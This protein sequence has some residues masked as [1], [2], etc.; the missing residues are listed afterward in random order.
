LASADLPVQTYSFSGAP[1]Y[2]TAGSTTPSATSAKAAAIYVSQPTKIS[3]IFY[4]VTTAD[5]TS[6]AYDFGYYGPGCYNAAASIPLAFHTGLTAGTSLASGTGLTQYAITSG[7][8]T[9][10]PGWYCFVISTSATSSIN[11]VLG[12]AGLNLWVPFAASSSITTTGGVLPG[13]IT[14][15]NLSWQRQQWLYLGTTY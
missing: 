5:N 13:T 3:N 9:I 7:P 6:N 4:S 2:T 12:G 15:P 1:S 14:A 10:Q 8:V 11:L